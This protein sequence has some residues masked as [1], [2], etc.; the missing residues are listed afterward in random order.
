MRLSLKAAAVLPVALAPLLLPAYAS[1][2]VPVP[3]TITGNIARGTIDLP[4]GVGAQLTL[5]FETVTGL[6]PDALAVTA[7]LVDPNDPALRARLPGRPLLPWLPPPVT[8]PAAFPVLLHIT[9][10]PSSALSFTGLYNISI[11]THNLQLDPDVPFALHKAEDGGPF[12]DI[13]VTEGIGSYRAGGGGGDFSDFLI[14][15]DRRNINTVILQKFAALSALLTEH[16]LSIPPAVL[17]SLLDRLAS[18]RTL[19]LTGNLLP[20]IAEITAFSQDVIA[21]S[22]GGEIPDVWQAS[23]GSVNVAGL[24]RSAADTLRFSLDRKASR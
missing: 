21:H 6:D 22:G 23:G 1:A 17:T 24:L 2:Q 19:F 4:G 3:L 16:A 8:I 10:T 11:Y 13:M 9:P 5:T 18:T 7:T 12:H 15:V 20:A 14:V